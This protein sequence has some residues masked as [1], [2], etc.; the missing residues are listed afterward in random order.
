[1]RAGL[2]DGRLA[3]A[4]AP[5]A[6]HRPDRREYL[7]RSTVLELAGVRGQYRLSHHGCTAAG[8]GSHVPGHCLCQS[9]G[10]AAKA[11]PRSVSG[12]DPVHGDHPVGGDLL[13]RASV[14]PRI[15]WDSFPCSRDA[16]D[17]LRSHR[18]PGAVGPDLERRRFPALSPGP[19]DSLG[20]RCD[21]YPGDAA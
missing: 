3:A 11:R 14:P 15:L 9:G 6:P 17:H 7:H 21:G 8:H 4:L 12:H 2:P 13:D 10:L 5:V 20:I 18:H 16:S 1:M 19:G